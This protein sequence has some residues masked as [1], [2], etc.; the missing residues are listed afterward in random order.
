M[1]LSTKTPA[2][3]RP[4]W[5]SVREQPRETFRLVSAVAAALPVVLL[6][7]MGYA[8]RWVT[9]DAFINFRVVQHVLAG[10]GPVFNA[11]E[12]VE[13]FTSPLWLA[14]LSLWAALRGPLEIGSLAIGLILAGI[15]LALA[16]AAAWRLARRLAPDAWDE[17]TRPG[18]DHLALP[19]GA[20]VFAAVPVAW[21]FTT[22]GLE[23]GLTMAWLG[24][25]FWLLARARP[26]TM[27]GARAAA[28][29]IGCGPLVR[30]DLLVFSVGFGAALVVI[31][32][33]ASVPRLSTG[34]WAGLAIVGTALPL[35]YQVFRMGY[36]AALV[37]NTALAKEASA[38]Y[39]AQG[40]QYA[41]DFTGVYVLWLPAMAAA[42]WAGALLWSA[43]RTERLPAE[44]ALVLAPMLSA[45]AHA[46]YVTRVGGDFM[47]GR[48]LLPSLLGF[49]LPVATVLVPV[50]GS[51]AGRLA[52]LAAVGGW[53]LVCALWL[54]VPYAG[55]GVPGPKGIADERGFYVHHMQTPNPIYLA[56][57]LKH[58]FVAQ[59]TSGQLAFS[60]AVVL[61][62]PGQGL[63]QAS[64]IVPSAPR[65]ARI[66]LGLS[67][68]G[69]LGYAVGSDVH[70]VDRLG[71]ADPLASRLVLATRDRPGHEKMLPDAWIVARFGDP[72]RATVAGM[73]EA[74]DA[75]RAL[76]CG[77]LAR[78]LHAVAD[79][80]TPSRFLLNI[81]E[82]WTLHRLRI[83]GDP[84]SARRRLCGPSGSG[85]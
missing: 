10:H 28:F 11:G 80:L 74:L 81:R 30:P 85:S 35:G 19:L 1:E 46:L 43:R 45:L 5:S 23:S 82:A 60:G 77:D 71:L 76:G 52:A 62:R 64:A 20:V 72:A 73:P 7:G 21:D 2:E 53:A 61:E 36:F 25:V 57:Y 22:S 37:P 75:G 3:L 55:G 27:R 68:V 34:Q 78:L 47:H 18:D 39:W 38:P 48:L 63:V 12:R 44:A 69:V 40:W 33:G 9:E 13:A 79:P 59:V 26:M 54:R 29:A 65:S 17:S 8:R 24:G 6:V 67:N 41:L 56:D 42:A 32:R 83:P 15:G 66:V 84:A 70:V 50:R 31:A 16:Q 14:V 51:R 4:V 49:L 58:P